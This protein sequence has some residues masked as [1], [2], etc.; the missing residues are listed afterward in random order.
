MARSWGLGSHRGLLMATN[1]LRLGCEDEGRKVEAVPGPVGASTP[2]PLA[3][4]DLWPLLRVR[5]P[6]ANR[7]TRPLP[8]FVQ[9]LPGLA[10]MLL[11]TLGPGF[12]FLFPHRK[13]SS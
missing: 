5:S 7:S 8:L 4:P 6:S 12:P 13:E 11:D 2:A 10:T 9:H 1:G 3:H